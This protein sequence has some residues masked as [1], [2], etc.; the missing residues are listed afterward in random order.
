MNLTYSSGWFYPDGW[1]PL[2]RGQ[3]GHRVQEL[4]QAGQQVVA[5]HGLPING[6]NFKRRNRSTASP[7]CL[8]RPFDTVGLINKLYMCT[9]R[10]HSKKFML[11]REIKLNLNVYKYVYTNIFFF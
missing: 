2:S 11:G 3:D 10:T 5:L 4:V 9:K 8:L 6:I 7:K 1:V